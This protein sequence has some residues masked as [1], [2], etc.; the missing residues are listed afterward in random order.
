[1]PNLHTV[2]VIFYVP[3]RFEAGGFEEAGSARFD[4]DLNERLLRWDA[5][6]MLQAVILDARKGSTSLGELPLSSVVAMADFPNLDPARLAVN[7]LG[8]EQ[9]TGKQGN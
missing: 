5:A 1:M 7:G 4:I 2:D 8:Q 9:H 3:H 6:G